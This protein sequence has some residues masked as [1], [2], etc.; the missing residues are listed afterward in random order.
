VAALLVPESAR[1]IFPGAWRALALAQPLNALSFVTDGIHWGTRD[2]RYL[3]NAMFVA[4]ALG[5]ALLFA[6]P[7]RGADSLLLV[8][9]IT[10]LWI[11][12]RATFGVGRVWPGWGRAPLS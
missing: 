7:V 1:G 2:Y 10:A 8:W 5:T 3:R 12:V 4:T 6:L 11:V 9:L